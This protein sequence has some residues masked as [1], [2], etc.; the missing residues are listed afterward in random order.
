MSPGRD[1]KEQ[2]GTAGKPVPFRQANDWLIAL[3]REF[4]GDD[5]R[6]LPRWTLAMT[7]AW[8]VWRS[9]DAVLD[10]L[11]FARHDIDLHERSQRLDEPPFLHQANRQPGSVACVFEEAGLA[12]GTRPVVQMQDYPPPNPSTENLY[13]RLKFA[14]QG[15]RLRAT[16]VY[17]SSTRATTINEEE[18]RRD[19]W[20]DFD[21]FADPPVERWADDSPPTTWS[22]Y[23]HWSDPKT[24]LVVVRREDALRVDQD[25]CLREFQSPTWSVSQALG[26]LAYRNQNEFRSLQ[27]RDVE[28]RRFLASEYPKDWSDPDPTG[29]LTS[30]LLSG[31]LKARRERHELTELEIG[32]IIHGGLWS[33][34]ELWV[35]PEDVKKLPVKQPARDN[36]RSSTESKA[37][38]LLAEHLKTKSDDTETAM[39]QHLVKAVAPATL[40]KKGFKNRI[41]PA[42]REKAGVLPRGRGRPRRVKGSSKATP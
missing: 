21:S 23:P 37:I 15:G 7:A 28:R 16:R 10:Q 34:K 26:W 24:D 8:F 22:S 27:P 12:E 35:Y 19:D 36:V 3:L 17:R 11:K 1:S 20:T 25:L 31:K 2:S 9:Y 41:L 4:D 32:A 13:D 30:A 5:V 39:F 42:A 14:L 40:S 33:H 38:Q 29:A 18:I 6:A